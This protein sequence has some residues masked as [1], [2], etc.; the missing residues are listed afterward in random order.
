MRL[1]QRLFYA[2]PILN[3]LVPQ[4]GQKPRVA[5]LLFFMVICMGFLISTFCRH[6]TQSA[7]YGYGGWRSLFGA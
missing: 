4:F 6:F 1:V 7:F 5:G 3:T 2:L